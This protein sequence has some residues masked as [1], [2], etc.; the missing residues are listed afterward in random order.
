M[1]KDLFTDGIS[2]IDVDEVAR[3]LQI[4]QDL[5]AK[6]ARQ[7]RMR[8][9]I[10]PAAAL[11]ALLV[12]MTA[13]IIPFIP[14]TL[15][16]EYE[17]VE[18]LP[19]NVWV[20]YVNDRGA[21]KRE[22]VNLP[23]GA[24]NV[25]AAWKHLN[26]VDDAVEILHYE[27]AADQQMDAAVIPDTLWE[28]LKQ[29]FAP[30]AGQK[31]VTITLS[32]QITSCENYDALIESLKETLAKYAGVTPEQVKIL[33]DGKQDIQ[34]SQLSFWNSLENSPVTVTVGSSLEITV[35]MTN[36]SDQ[37]LEFS[38][39]WSAAAPNAILTMNDTNVILHEDSPMTEEYQ[40]YILAPG[41]S[42]E[43][44]YTFLVPPNAAPGTYDLCISYGSLIRIYKNAVT[45]VKPETQ[46]AIDYTEFAKFLEKYRLNTADPVSFK[47]ALGIF[48][49][50]HESL[51][52]QM[53][54]ADT[55]WAPN[56]SGEVWVHDQFTY[57]YSILTQNGVMQSCK[58]DFSAR[59]VPGGM[60]LPHGIT[61]EDSL[62]D[63]LCKMG[64]DS[65]DANQLLFESI[66]GAGTVVLAADDTHVLDIGAAGSYL[67]VYR[68]ENENSTNELIFYYDKDLCFTQFEVKTKGTPQFVPSVP[69]YNYIGLLFP[70]SGAELPR[71]I[72]QKIVSAMKN[73]ICD[74]QTLCD[75]GYI[76]FECM[77]GS[78]HSSINYCGSHFHINSY[79]WSPTDADKIFID[80]LIRALELYKGEDGY[81]A[82][83]YYDGN[84][85]GHS[86]SVDEAY[87]STQMGDG[88]ITITTDHLLAIK[89]PWENG[90]V[91]RD[92]YPTNDFLLFEDGT[93][94]ERIPTAAPKLAVRNMLQLS[95][96]QGKDCN[97][98][99]TGTDV[100][101]IRNILT[102]V[103][104]WELIPY[105]DLAYDTKIIVNNYTVCI[106]AYGDMKIGDYVAIG[107][108]DAE[109]LLDILARHYKMY[110]Q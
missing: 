45:I 42:R 98:T 17:P 75:V 84:F 90:L 41:E 16:I 49:Y 50:N 97:V 99:I 43:F 36:I 105:S 13:V 11:L 33:I 63:A 23:G 51:L 61:P 30:A 54:P 110:Y 2:H 66:P 46:Y 28:Y 57:S 76:V 70:F 101:Q 26:E 4:E 77:E 108:F 44:T 79:A 71:E 15:D 35:G 5:Q 37:N 59:V 38:G 96:Y 10:I 92:C 3:L 20:Y 83:L 88:L 67:L 64:Y 91:G 56:Y 52:D 53:T 34:I 21:Q 55:E 24:E 73:S 100:T 107:D 93:C 78:S 22:R 48:T 19:E 58:N 95:Q 8:L 14:K 60:T 103:Q 9:L 85:Y 25:F 6:K 104:S 106:N 31:T 94:F 80:T 82:L 62:L 72:Q 81:D 32:P 65:Q 86:A 102:G 39:S 74:G 12:C 1:K 47:E 89:A 87:Q 29:E 27:E 109:A 18:G 7:K 40:K 68:E 69:N